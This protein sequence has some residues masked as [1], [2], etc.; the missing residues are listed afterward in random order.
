MNTL[1]LSSFIK[2]S[3]CRRRKL[4]RVPSGL[5]RASLCLATAAGFLS[6]FS[7]A[8]V[9]QQFTNV[10]TEAG[11]VAILTRT[12]GNPIWGDLNGDGNLDLIVPKHELIEVTVAIK[13]IGRAP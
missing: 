2:P 11:M 3:F 1:P 5:K 7:S 12:W 10:S 8:C 9:A 13:E 4:C 6:V